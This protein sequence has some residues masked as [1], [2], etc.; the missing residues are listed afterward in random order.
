MAGRGF[1]RSALTGAQD[2]EHRLDTDADDAALLIKHLSK[3][4]AIVLGNSSGAIVSLQLLTRHPGIIRTL[5][6]HEPPA[7]KLLPDFEEL[8]KAQQ[9]V[10]D[11]YRQSGVLPAFGKFIQLT[12][13]EREAADFAQAIGNPENPYSFSNIQ[14][15]F[16]RELL[17]YP[18]VEF[19]MEILTAEKDKLLL[20]NG[21]D[22]I[23]E[24]LQYRPNT[25][26]ASRLALNLTTMPG[27]HLGWA[28]KPQEFSEK[29]MEL[30][31][32]TGVTTA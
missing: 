31:K 8:W 15:W 14:Y 12:K 1:S 10:Y 27:A 30:L 32:Y 16:E 25:V 29:L 23:P 19:D 7:M 24:T 4:P 21:E 17:Y 20:L 13:T 5:I 22:T 3:E 9:D 11:T 28:V 6:P 2:Y 26:L 18:A